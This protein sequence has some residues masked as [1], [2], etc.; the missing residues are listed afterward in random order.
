MATIFP[1]TELAAEPQV[2]GSGVGSE[3]PEDTRDS[4]VPLLGPFSRLDHAA[5]HKPELISFHQSYGDAQAKGRARCRAFAFVIPLLVVTLMTAVMSYRHIC[6]HGGDH[7][8]VE[9]T[10]IVAVHG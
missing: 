4:R 9:A 3:F 6:P 5:E 10:N 7:P 8:M 2:V 1:G